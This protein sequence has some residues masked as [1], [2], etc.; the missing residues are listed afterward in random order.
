MVIVFIIICM[1]FSDHVFP[2]WLWVLLI[3]SILIEGA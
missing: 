1:A 3:L 2:T